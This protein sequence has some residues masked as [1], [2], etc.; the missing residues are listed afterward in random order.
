[1][2]AVCWARSGHLSVS[3]TTYNFHSEYLKPFFDTAPLPDATEAFHCEHRVRLIANSDYRC[4][5]GSRDIKNVNREIRTNVAFLSYKHTSIPSLSST[6]RQM[7]NS[8]EPVCKPKCWCS[9]AIGICL[10]V[11]AVS[12]H[13]MLMI[14][15]SCKNNSKYNA[16]TIT[17]S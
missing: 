10:C 16:S 5:E 1:M 12:K 4:R 8:H 7:W 17:I 13:H 6:P 9:W 3:R 11:L 14:E 15:A 2:L